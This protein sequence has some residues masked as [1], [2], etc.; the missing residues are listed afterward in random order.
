MILRY[1][2]RIIA[3]AVRSA[4][5][6]AS[7]ATASE[8]PGTHGN[9]PGAT[10]YPPTITPGGVVSFPAEQLPLMQQFTAWID[11]PAGHPDAEQMCQRLLVEVGGEYHFRR[12]CQAAKAARLPMPRRVAS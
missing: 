3:Q 11:L 8:A 10:I 9:A 1:L 7:N 2:T 4:S 5:S 6:P 12:W